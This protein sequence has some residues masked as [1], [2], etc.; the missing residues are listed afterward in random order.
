MAFG[1]GCIDR[2]DV[3]SSFANT[4]VDR[5]AGKM[6]R[7]F[8]QR[9]DEVLCKLGEGDSRRELLTDHYQIDLGWLD[10]MLARWPALRSSAR[11]S[12]EPTAGSRGFHGNAMRV[13]HGMVTGEP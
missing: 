8:F 1:S 5:L 4:H 9:V 11:Q 2:P 3:S 12:F 7:A 10:G 6:H 13:E